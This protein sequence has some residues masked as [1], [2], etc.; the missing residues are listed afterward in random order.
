MHRPRITLFVGTVEAPNVRFRTEGRL[1]ITRLRIVD[2]AE[3]IVIGRDHNP[4]IKR[5]NH[6]KGG[7]TSKR[8]GD[9]DPE[10]RPDTEMGGVG[11]A[12][13]RGAGSPLG[14][15]RAPDG[16]GP[17]R[18]DQA[19]SVRV[20]IRV[21]PAA[22]SVT[23]IL[24]CPVL[25][26]G[27]AGRSQQTVTVMMPARSVCPC[28]KGRPHQQTYLWGSSATG[29]VSRRPPPN[30]LSRGGALGRHSGGG[31]DTRSCDRR[32]PGNKGRSPQSRGDAP[33]RR[34]SIA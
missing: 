15:S 12:R 32:K 8:G 2:L 16:C 20:T 6:R 9:G 3:D 1:Y 34:A 18:P 28:P 31:I 11:G 25:A 5:S 26:R 29:P 22:A 21:L 17:A 24:S 27:A 13:P 4:L 19:R 33:A 23:V 7:A 14:F 30:D 10:R